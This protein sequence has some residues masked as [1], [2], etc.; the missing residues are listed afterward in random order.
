MKAIQRLRS[1][2]LLTGMAV[3]ITPT[4]FFAGPAYAEAATCR[5]GHMCFWWDQGYNG[6]LFATSTSQA[7]LDVWG[8]GDSDEAHSLHNRTGV[9]WLVYDDK[10][11]D[12]TDR[13]FCVMSGVRNYDIGTGPYR[14][15][16]KISSVRRLGSNRCPAG[17]PKIYS[18]S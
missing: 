6:R 4:A 7:D 8:R 10:K 17:V 13:H 12:A 18:N 11:Y 15:G 5:K 1:M 3:A 2:A 16:D 9:A 14:I